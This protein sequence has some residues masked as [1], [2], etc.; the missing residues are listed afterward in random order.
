M[1][2]K[3]KKSSCSDSCSSSSSSDCDYGYKQCNKKYNII[4]PDNFR[5][6]KCYNFIKV[7]KGYLSIG[8]EA[9]SST[10]QFSSAGT[11][12][13]INLKIINTGSIPLCYPVQITSNDGG[14]QYFD[15]VFILPG[16]S[17]T[18]HTNYT[19]TNA[20]ISAGAVIRQ[21]TPYMNIKCKKCLTSCPAVLTIPFV[22]S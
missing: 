4:C 9:T 11:N 19:T 3:H 14:S 10:T 13:I 1:G 5:W 12:I 18:Y 8:L 7:K 17:Y 21:Y 2:K 15:A 22:Q 16:A 6:N 20:D